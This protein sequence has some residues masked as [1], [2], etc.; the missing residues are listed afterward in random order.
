MFKEEKLQKYML[1][2]TK[3]GSRD[4]AKQTT[5]K[6]QYVVDLDWNELDK[7]MKFASPR[8]PLKHKYI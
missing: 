1:C 4:N 8:S 6:N 7:T 2:L 5:N 3:S